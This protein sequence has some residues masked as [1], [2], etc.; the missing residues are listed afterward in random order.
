M[1]AFSA[2]AEVMDGYEVSREMKAFWNVEA[3]ILQKF[4]A[5]CEKHGL[6]WFAIGGTLLG[7]VRHKSFIPWDDDMDVAMPQDDYE[8]LC[9]IAEEEFQYPY[10]FQLYN[11]DPYAAPWHAK[12]R[13]SDT[14]GYSVYEDK[15]MPETFNKGIFFD[16]FPLSDIPDDE[17]EREK[18]FRR[19]AYWKK[20][21]E[22]KR[23]VEGKPEHIK[24][25]KNGGIKTKIHDLLFI[26]MINYN[27]LC[28]WYIKMCSKHYSGKEIGLVSIYPGMKSLQWPR[29]WFEE[30]VD[31]P[32]G[33]ITVKAPKE[34]DKVLTVEYGDYMTPV[35]GIQLHTDVV[36]DANKPYSE[37]STK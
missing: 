37:Y 16:V 20:K 28:D 6:R 1:I 3:D 26:R 27:K 2:D 34:Y 22:L 5:V 36:I 35:K 23:R 10:F 14:T 15:N 33:L 4:S 25:R 18:L 30:T 9:K 8:R 7:A 19:I 17:K 31:L 32:F 13:R 24:A 21:I 12:I 11:T 29:E